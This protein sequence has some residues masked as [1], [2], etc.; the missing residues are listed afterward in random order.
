MVIN[1]ISK[2]KNITFVVITEFF[3]ISDAIKWTAISFGGFILGLSSLNIY[4]NIKPLFVFLV[5]TLFI[6]SFT[7]AINNYFDA[8]SDREN[9]RRRKINAIAS[10]RISK[11]TAV[12]LIIISAIIPLIVSI[13][14]KFEIF[15]FCGFLLFLGWAYSARPFRFKGRLV[16]DVIWHFLGFFTYVIWGSLIAGSIGLISWLAAISIGAFSL[17]G[18]VENHIYDYSFDKKSGTKTLAVWLGLNKAKIILTILAFLHLILLIPLILLYTISYYITILSTIIIAALGLLFL[19]QK[20]EPLSTQMFFVKYSTYMLGGAVYLSC[21]I[22]QIL[23][24]LETPTL[25]LLNS[26]GIL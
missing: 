19:K 12:F 24:L 22:Y 4:D 8:D 16:M 26:I 5:S 2:K 7:F 11:Q 17:V 20:K 3:R 1:R 23:F 18:Q 6:M 15:V 21:L 9:P 25:G 10:G 14:F 13:F